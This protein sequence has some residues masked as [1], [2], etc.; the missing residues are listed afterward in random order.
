ML[1]KRFINSFII[2]VILL[3]VLFGDD[4]VWKNSTGSTG[5]KGLETAKKVYIGPAEGFRSPGQLNVSGR[6]QAQEVEIVSPAQLSGFPDY[7]FDDDYQLKSVL[8]VEQY[9]IENQHLE[10]LPG[11]EEVQ[12]QGMNALAMQKLLLKQIEELTLYTINQQQRLEQLHREV[13][14][15]KSAKGG[16]GHVK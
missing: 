12:E 7:V 15:M 16:D 2:F 1:N 4:N 3:S 6:I 9:I 5:S 10:D 13:N 14:E 8:E 11:A